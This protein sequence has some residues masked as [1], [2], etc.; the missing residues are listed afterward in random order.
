MK[1]WLKMIVIILI[2]AVC[3]YLIVYGQRQTGVRELVLMLIGLT[4]LLGLLFTYNA[5]YKR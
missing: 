3:V 2:F 5:R 1:K 4:G